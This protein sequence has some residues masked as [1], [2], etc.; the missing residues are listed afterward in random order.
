[1]A[2]E[3]L[4]MDDWQTEGKVREVTILMLIVVDCG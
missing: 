1:M 4:W 2:Y 3:A